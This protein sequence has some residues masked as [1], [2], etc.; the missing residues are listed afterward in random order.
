[1]F[2]NCNNDTLTLSCFISSVFYMPLLLFGTAIDSATVF[3]PDFV[4]VIVSDIVSVVLSPRVVRSR[5]R[6][7]S[8]SCRTCRERSSPLVST[9]I[10][11]EIQENICLIWIQFYLVVCSKLEL[12]DINQLTVSVWPLLAAK[13]RG[14]ASSPSRMFTSTPLQT[15]RF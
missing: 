9:T 7:S 10:S 8:G 3:V 15:D 6:R 5:R 4:L 12:K 11:P 2:L 14:V 1:M 13:W